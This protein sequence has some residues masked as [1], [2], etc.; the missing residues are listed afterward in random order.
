[1]GGDSR[2]PKL[3]YLSARESLAIETGELEKQQP[4]LLAQQ[5]HRAREFLEFGRAIF[6]D[7]VVGD[8]A[9]NLGGKGEPLRGAGPP[10]LDSRGRGCAVEG[11]VDF[12]R[13]V[14]LEVFG[15]IAGGARSPADRSLPPSFRS[16]SSKR[17]GVSLGIAGKLKV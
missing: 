6:N 7:F 9:G 16:T 15:K 3:A 17:R 11:R 10:V 1:M 2:L 4:Q 5:F 13:V 12:D 14:V 8:G